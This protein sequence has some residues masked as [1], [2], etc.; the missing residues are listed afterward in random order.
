VQHGLPFAVVLCSFAS[1]GN[2]R[3][4]ETLSLLWSV[5]ASLSEG[6]ALSTVA[7]SL[8][9]VQPGADRRRR[10][11]LRAD[12]WCLWLERFLG[13]LMERHVGARPR[14][15]DGIRENSADRRC[16]VVQPAS[17]SSVALRG[18]QIGCR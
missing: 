15:L 12:S 4:F 10:L 5:N 16:L 1:L 3:S 18:Q 14:R 8:F 7:S 2:R 13:C 9:C 11:S 6:T 17:G